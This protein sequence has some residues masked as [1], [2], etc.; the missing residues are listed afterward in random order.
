MKRLVLSIAIAGFVA[1]GALNVQNVVA[2]STRI[3]MVKFDKD[4]K[5][6]KNKDKKADEKKDSKTDAKATTTEAKDAQTKSCDKPASGK[7]CCS[8]Q[9]EG[10]AKS[11][12][13]KK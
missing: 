6:D 12:P 2:S 9:K 5:K 7:S 3:S 13:E 11:C 1:F 8:P 10:C 4:P